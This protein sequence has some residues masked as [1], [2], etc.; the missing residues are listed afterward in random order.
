[1]VMILMVPSAIAGSAVQINVAVNG[2]FASHI[3]GAVSWLYYAFRLVQLPIGIFGVAIATVTLPA[4]ARQHALDDLAAFGKTVEGALRVLPDAAR[5]GRARGRGRAG[6]PD[7][8]PA[9]HVHR[10]GHGADR[11]GPAGL[12]HR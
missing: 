11:A 1:M 2:Q 6:D 9:R 3:D 12:H 10:A 8:L 5:V 4:V 7:H